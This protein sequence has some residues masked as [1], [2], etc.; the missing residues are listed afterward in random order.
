MVIFF[1]IIDLINNLL[2][3]HTRILTLGITWQKS[4]IKF[5]NK[6]YHI[7]WEQY[8]KYKWWWKWSSKWNNLRENL[9]DF[10]SNYNLNCYI[11]YNPINKILIY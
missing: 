11:Q 4:S 10:I 1:I 3:L 2:K 5:F 8:N 9:Y 6:F 7:K